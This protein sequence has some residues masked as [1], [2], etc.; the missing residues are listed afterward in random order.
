M[1]SRFGRSIL[2][3][4]NKANPTYFTDLVGFDFDSDEMT[5]NEKLMVLFGTDSTKSEW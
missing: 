2:S 3:M 5:E 1:H 4:Y